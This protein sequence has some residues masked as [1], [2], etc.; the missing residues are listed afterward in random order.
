[1][2]KEQ[3]RNVIEDITQDNISLREELENLKSGKVK[4]V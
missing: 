1:M 3:M 2:F 4:E